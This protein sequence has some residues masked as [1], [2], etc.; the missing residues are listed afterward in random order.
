VNTKLTLRLDEDLIR[1]AKRHAAASGKS[2][3]QLVEDY[4][5]V[6]VATGGPVAGEL[7]PRVRGLLGAL[8]E[9]AGGGGLDE[10]AYRAHLERRHTGRSRG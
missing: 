6:L 8:K 10:G 1:G 7:T 3:S 4:F 5:T 2:V 9:G